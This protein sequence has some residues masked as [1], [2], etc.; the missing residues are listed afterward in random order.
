MRHFPRNCLNRCGLNRA[1][2]LPVVAPAGGLSPQ[3]QLLQV[4]IYEATRQKITRSFVRAVD[5]RGIRDIKFL[6]ETLLRRQPAVY[7]FSA[8]LPAVFRAPFGPN[9]YRSK[10]LA[11]STSNFRHRVHAGNFS[12]LLSPCDARAVHKGHP[13]RRRKRRRRKR[14]R[15]S[16]PIRV[17]I[18]EL[19]RY[20]RH[21]M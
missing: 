9:N 20:E 12:L 15:M 2:T 4:C 11:G 17:I 7:T 6:P 10:K 18:R 13:G 3:R 21:F 14:R 16:R 8:R 1:A 19:A 5:S